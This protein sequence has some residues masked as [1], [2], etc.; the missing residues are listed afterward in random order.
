MSFKP[1][2]IVSSVVALVLGLGYLFA[3]TLVVGR[4]RIEPTESVLLLG[5]RMGALYLGLSIIFFLARSAPR[6]VART[7]LC[8]GTST[9]LALLGSLGIYELSAGR[10]GAGIVASIGIEFL[11]ALS[12]VMVVVTERKAVVGG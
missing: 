4:W 11:L 6:S 3:G 10:V 8:V 1:V 5:R 7:A 12:F 9:A 2:A